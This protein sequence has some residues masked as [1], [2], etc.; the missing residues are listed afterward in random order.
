VIL[1]SIIHLSL[2]DT[3]ASF[4]WGGPLSYHKQQGDLLAVLG[5]ITFAHILR[6]KITNSRCDLLDFTVHLLYAFSPPIE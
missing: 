5:K 3:S 6:E 1:L 4:T 2:R